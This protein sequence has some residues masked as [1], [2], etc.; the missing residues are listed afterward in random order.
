MKTANSPWYLK[1]SPTTRIGPRTS[2]FDNY[3]SAIF[4]SSLDEAPGRPCRAVVAARSPGSNVGSTRSLRLRGPSS[5]PAKTS[6]ERMPADA[7]ITD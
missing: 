1:T 5:S 2:E 7:R 6:D 3:S 4:P